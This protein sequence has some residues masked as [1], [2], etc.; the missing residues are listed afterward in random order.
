MD[1]ETLVT[2]GI[3][4]GRRL[5][6]SLYDDREFDLRAAFWDAREDDQDG[7][8]DYSLTLVSGRVGELTRRELL[9]RALA[10]LDSQK[11]GEALADLRVDILGPDEPRAAAI[12]KWLETQS[13]RPDT[14]IGRRMLDRQ[15]IT[16][17]YVYKPRTT[18][19]SYCDGEVKREPTATA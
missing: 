3:E 6:E 2:Q 17:A 11:L 5:V 1:S 14:W 13:G 16:H 18:K 19:M 12:L 8:I 7:W 4:I 15:Y 10:L 9:S